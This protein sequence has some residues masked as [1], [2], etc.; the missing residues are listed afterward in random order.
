[1]GTPAARVSEQVV[2]VVD[3][4]ETVCR[5][6]ARVLANAGFRVLAAHDGEEAVALLASLSPV[7]WL[8]VSDIDMPRMTGVEL[9]A[10]TAARWPAVTVLLVSGQGGPP[11]SYEGRFLRKP[12]AP[13]ELIATVDELLPRVQHSSGSA[14]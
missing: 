8:V 14:E 10:V 2:L 1:M 3:D 13:D 4:E 11:R 7:V 5:Y 12:F 6:T 9:A